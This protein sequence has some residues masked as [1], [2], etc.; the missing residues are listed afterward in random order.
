MNQDQENQFRNILGDKL[1]D[2]QMDAPGI[3]WADH[4][5]YT[6]KKKK[7]RVLFWWTLA[8]SLFFIGAIAFAVFTHKSNSHIATTE[9]I[10]I[11]KKQSRV[12]API[13]NYSFKS[14]DNPVKFGISDQLNSDKSARNVTRNNS[15]NV[16]Q[17]VLKTADNNIAIPQ[18][19]NDTAKRLRIAYPEIYGLNIRQE[20]FPVVLPRTLLADNIYGYKSKSFSRPYF[21]PGLYWDV[22]VNLA[23]VQPRFAVTNLGKAFVHK[24]YQ[25]IRN[26]SENGLYGVGLNAMIGKRFSKWSISAGL[27]ISVSELKGI[28]DYTYSEKPI[29]DINGRI[30]NYASSSPVQVSFTAKQKMIFT[31]LPISANIFCGRNRIHF[32]ISDHVYPSVFNSVEGSLPNSVML[33]EKK[34]CKMGILKIP[35]MPL[36]WI[37]RSKGYWGQFSNLLYPILPF[38]FGIKS[39]LSLYG[40]KINNLGISCGFTSHF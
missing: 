2:A 39:G 26:S 5:Q 23:A 24:D 32:G 22:H 9:K 38:W 6:E 8:A 36:N 35:A 13:E 28:Y 7:K 29:I 37:S 15:P 27:G 30:V 33:N 4:L 12:P 17:T 34:F 19:L 21:A 31:E 1:F 3:S 11:D 16:P 18:T 14:G 10:S 20:F 40:T 25:G